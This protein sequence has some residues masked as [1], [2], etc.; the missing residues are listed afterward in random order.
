[1]DTHQRASG[2]M[3]LHAMANGLPVVAGEGG[4]VFDLVEDGVDG[5]IVPRSDPETLAQRILMLVQNP[6]ERLRMG[7]AGFRKADEGYRP[8]D[9]ATACAGVYDALLRGEPLPRNPDIP[10]TSR[11]K[12]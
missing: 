4:A 11:S 3:V 2:Q 7:R 5:V 8:A 9:M 1:V 6:A 10:R 12:G